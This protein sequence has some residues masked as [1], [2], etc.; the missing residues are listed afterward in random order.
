MPAV[1]QFGR[2]VAQGR[3]YQIAQLISQVFH[4]ALN[5]VAA[6]FVA[7]LLSQA[8]TSR[9]DQLWWAGLCIVILITPT[10]FYFYSRLRRGDFSDADVLRRTERNRLFVVSLTATVVGSVLLALLGVPPIFLRLVAGAVLVV[11]TCGLINLRWKISLHAAS[12][13]TLATLIAVLGQ[14]G[15][16]WS[17]WLV[18]LAVGWARVRTGN[19][20]PQ[21]V[22]A[23]WLVAA[24]GITLVLRLG[25]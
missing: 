22:A 1:D 17:Y 20:T 19:H 4:P 24:L 18:A 23:G 16:R 25:L 5:A 11:G 9:L 3:G 8:R 15:W 21:Q 2:A 10:L 12:V 6:F 14:G 13:A 7:A